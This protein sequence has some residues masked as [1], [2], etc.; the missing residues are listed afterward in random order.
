MKT[1]I[2]VIAAAA[3]L[4]GCATVP[5]GRY[6]YNQSRDPSQW[7][8]VSVTPVPTGTAARVAAGSPD[9][10]RVEYSSSPIVV[11]QP[12][13]TQPSYMYSQP[14]YMYTQPSYYYPPVALSLG[15]GFVFG[16]HWSSGRHHRGHS[17]RGRR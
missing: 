3:I 4:T 5:D 12:V 7:Q 9:G 10:S 15:L 11:T 2:I 16:R 6:G 1:P 8:T 17:G 14:S 13:Y